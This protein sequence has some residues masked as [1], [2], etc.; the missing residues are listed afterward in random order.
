MS[1]KTLDQLNAELITVDAALEKL[2]QGEKLTKFTIGSGDFV[3]T[4]EYSEISYESLKLLRKEIC[5]AIAIL[6][7]ALQKFRAGTIPLVVTKFGC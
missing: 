6:T 2:I 5:E 1:A 4:Y 7:P 3:R